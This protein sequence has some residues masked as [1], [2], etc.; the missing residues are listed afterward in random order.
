MAVMVEKLRK[1]R[2]RFGGSSGSSRLA[3]SAT[4]IEAPVEPRQSPVLVLQN[5]VASVITSRRRTKLSGRV[6]HA[7]AG[8][9]PF[10]L[11]RV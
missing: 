9:G 10:W 7:K 1:R 6:G 8:L 2:T 3:T 5:E 4:E 11:G